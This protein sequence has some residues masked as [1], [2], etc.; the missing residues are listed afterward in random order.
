MAIQA[1]SHT[2]STLLYLRF[3]R[4]AFCRER[5]AVFLSVNELELRKAQFN[6]SLPPGEVEFLDPGL[7]QVG[8]LE[9]SGSAE[10]LGNTLGEIRVQGQLRVAMEADCDRCLETARHSLES[11]FDLFYRLA[12]PVHAHHADEE[13][14]LDEGE[15]EIAFYE[16]GG[17]D[18]RDILRE[19]IL[20]SMPMQ[21]ICSETCK[22]ICPEC[23]QNRN[24][25]QCDCHAKLGDDRWA[26][27]KNLNAKGN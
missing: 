4:P 11:S 3:V 17:L 23:G 22:G 6:I 20:L 8:P 27:L 15:A 19:H 21:R 1:I 18:L 14:E 9:A 16:G 24:I 13:V 25:A 7:R 10:L 26:A 2:E 12:A 5:C